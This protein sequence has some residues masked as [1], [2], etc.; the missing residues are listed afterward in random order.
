M[1]NITKLTNE[2]R[3]AGI[4]THGNCNSNGIVW[5]DDNKE[6][7]DRKDV[8]AILKVHDPIPAPVETFEEKIA[9]EVEKQLRKKQ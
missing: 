7:Q 8:K 4:T 1:I 2:L 3:D 9:K 6:I 5:D